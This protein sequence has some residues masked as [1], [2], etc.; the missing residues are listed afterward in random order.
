M[1]LFLFTLTYLLPIV[2]WGSPI[3]EHEP[4]ER[5]AFQR[6]PQARAVP[7]RPGN[8]RCYYVSPVDGSRQPYYVRIP[9]DA[10]PDRELAVV[11]LLHGFGG[12]TH[13][14]RRSAFTRW[15]DTHSW[16]LVV[17]DG[18]GN[19][20][21]DHIGEADLLAVLRDLYR[22]TPY[23]PPFRIDA[24]RVFAAGCSM[25]GHGCYRAAFRYPHLFRAVAPSAGWTTY[26]EFYQHWYDRATAP[27]LPG[28]VDPAR[29]PL[30]E[31]ASSAWQAANGLNV[32][33]FV[34]YDLNDNVNPPQ[35]PRA[36]L[37]KLRALGHTCF[38]ER[39]G[40][41]G[42]C[43]S[44]SPEHAARFFAAFSSK[45]ADIR[46][47]VFRTNDLRRNRAHWVILNSLRTLNGWATVDARA[48]KQHI[49]LRTDNVL[50]LTLN[51]VE[52]PVDHE[53]PVEIIINERFKLPSPASDSVTVAASLDY[54]YDVRNW[55]ISSDTSHS[56]MRKKSTM[57]G[58][59]ADV[60]LDRFVVIYGTRGGTLG[61]D[62]SNPDWTAAQRF[63]TDWNARM[64]L[65]WRAQRPDK[66]RREDWWQPPYPFEPGRHI[67]PSQT[68]L[69]PLPDT[70]FTLENLPSDSNMVLFGGPAT[71]WIIGQMR[72]NLPVTPVSSINGGGI[73]V[74]ARRYTG[75]HIRYAFVAP[76]PLKNDRYVLISRGYPHSSISPARWTSTRV[77]KDLEGLP[78]YWPD[79]VVWDRRIKAGW[80]VQKPLRYLPDAWIE[81]GYF[82]ASW[83]LDKTPP[84]IS[85]ELDGAVD[86]DGR[87]TSSVQVRLAA[88]DAPGGFGLA[89]IQYKLEGGDWQR[90]KQPFTIAAEGEH[91]LYARAS[92][93]C[94]Q[95]IYRGNPATGAPAPGNTCIPQQF[96]FVIGNRAVP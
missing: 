88:R 11:F 95:Y 65:Q 58:P 4:E 26:R 54:T 37:G 73:R 62:E 18:R 25:G 52:A 15:G 48:G 85:A 50:S 24:D 5:G 49:Q 64:C 75:S 76:N 60:F 68:V 74:G 14:I 41:S 40:Q 93:Y 30:L 80:S 1:R 6:G 79:Y 70:M 2:V 86:A 21:W 63:A 53:K 89:S 67:P 31:R 71:N 61:A 7:M 91:T 22:R 20:N 10:D 17:P 81:A 32:G 87:F 90:Y 16:L 44:R 39:V 94:G 92:D 23:H 43:G 84:R 83:Q 28:Y 13:P 8:R 12:R 27:H 38:A 36:V 19:Q 33:L 29:R 66:H 9:G 72:D 34:T 59:L 46:H 55:C 3:P 47:V 82:D 51:L 57:A 35:N 42:H 69:H 77:G 96:H 56:A 45:P 78:F